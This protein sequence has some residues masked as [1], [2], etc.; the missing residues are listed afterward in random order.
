MNVAKRANAT[1][2]LDQQGRLRPFPVE[3]RALAEHGIQ[4]LALWLAE[5]NQAGQ[6]LAHRLGTAVE[7]QARLGCRI[8][9]I[10]GREAAGEE[11]A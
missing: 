9:G 4:T 5:A 11:Q 2:P 6:G 7:S 1:E 8:P 10:L 3:E